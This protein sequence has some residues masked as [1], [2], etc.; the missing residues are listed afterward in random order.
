MYVTFNDILTICFNGCDC[1]LVSWNPSVDQVFFHS[2]CKAE[3]R[4]SALVACSSQH[5]TRRRVWRCSKQR[6]SEMQ[7][8]NKKHQTSKSNMSHQIQP[9]KRICH[10]NCQLESFWIARLGHQ[11]SKAQIFNPAN[12]NSHFKID[13][14]PNGTFVS[15]WPLHRNF[16]N[17]L[18]PQVGTVRTCSIRA[19]RI[20]HMPLNLAIKV[21]MRMF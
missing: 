15:K 20:A 13:L 9:D 19:K 18:A 6:W 8:K 5:R 11:K 3:S 12:V 10:P 17:F 7:I 21:G 14:L 1:F 2:F 16:W 4:C